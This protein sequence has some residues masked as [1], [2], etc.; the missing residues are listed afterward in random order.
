M[1]LSIRTRIPGHSVAASYSV[2]PIHLGVLVTQVSKVSSVQ[3]VPINEAVIV[4]IHNRRSNKEVLGV[5]LVVVHV[6]EV[7]ILNSIRP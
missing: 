6:I 1:Y 4:S 5:V 2:F 7:I 3:Q